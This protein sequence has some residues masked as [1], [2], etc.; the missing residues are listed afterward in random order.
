MPAARKPAASRPLCLS[1]AAFLTSLGARL[2]ADVHRISAWR[3][4]EELLTYLEHLQADGRPPSRALIRTAALL[5][6]KL[7][8]LLFAPPFHRVDELARHLKRINQGQRPAVLWKDLDW[9]RLARLLLANRPL[10]TAL[11]FVE[12][13]PF[14]W[15]FKLELDLPFFARHVSAPLTVDQI[16][17]PT[18]GRQQLFEEAGN[19]I[20]SITNDLAD[21]QNILADLTHLDAGLP[22]RPL[23]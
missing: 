1:P 6:A 11:Y 7:S 18:V 13:A 21:A 9:F 3:A 14:A 5:I 12:P 16:R 23:R 10:H 4:A 20:Q 22:P 15:D 8:E 2:H 17:L 19:L